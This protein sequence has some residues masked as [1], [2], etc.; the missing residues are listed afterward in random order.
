MNTIQH[1]EA[2]RLLA[3]LENVDYGQLR[4]WDV[5][6]LV[7][8]TTAVLADLLDAADTFTTRWDATLAGDLAELITCPEA[9]ALTGLLAALGAHQLAATWATAHAAG[10]EPG[11]DHHPDEPIDGGC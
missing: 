2:R 3:D 9:D 6:E 4:E 8:R 11:D 10:D 7:G 5:V 1:T